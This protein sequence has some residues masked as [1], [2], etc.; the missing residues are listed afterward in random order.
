MSRA[1]SSRDR[2]GWAPWAPFVDRGPL[3]RTD[4]P[5][6]KR[7]LTAVNTHEANSV[8]G[9]AFRQLQ[10]GSLR[11]ILWKILEA[12]EHLGPAPFS[13]HSG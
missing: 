9:E 5:N 6:A 7:Y 8:L 3:V 1:S 13:P 11:P 12:R 2:G 4:S 10:P